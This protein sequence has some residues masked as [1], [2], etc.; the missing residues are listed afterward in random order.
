MKKRIRLIVAFSLIV[1]FCRAALP[2]KVVILTFDDAV[3]SQYN[4][5]A[6][7]L[8]DDGFGATFFVCEFPSKS[9]A[10]RQNYMTWKQIKELSDMGFEIGNHTKN[11][12]NI[13]KIS[14]DS[15]NAELGYID[16]RCREYHIDVPKV[17]AYPGY[18]RDS[19]S[20]SILK[21]RNYWF[22]RAGGNRPYKVGTDDPYQ[23]PSYDISGN[24]PDKV[25]RA[26]Q[27][28]KQGEVVILTIH[29]VPD[30]VHPWVNMPPELFRKYMDY[31]KK[32]NYTVWSLKTLYENLHVH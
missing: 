27:S 20:I 3:I 28:A 8:K 32:N 18:S 22:A 24:D 6:K 31:L 14:P 4:Y 11:H 2:E 29:G 12:V 21:K 13:T 15:L 17:F 10:E 19:L 16:S 25:Y 23:L 1:F 5:V 26:I 9:D 7:I 30:I